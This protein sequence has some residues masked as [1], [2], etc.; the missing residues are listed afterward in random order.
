MNQD[1]GSDVA[2]DTQGSEH[3]L[4]NPYY[5]PAVHVP[6]ALITY[7]GTTKDG[8]ELSIGAKMLYGRLSLYLG[9]PTPGKES[10]CNPKLVACRRDNVSADAARWIGVFPMDR[11]RVG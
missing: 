2:S 1:G 7:K 6:L 3:G 9:K 8:R 10:Y 11:L 5:L 4:F